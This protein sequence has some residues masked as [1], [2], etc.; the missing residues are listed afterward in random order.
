MTKSSNLSGSTSASLAFSTQISTPSQ[1]RVQCGCISVDTELHTSPTLPSTDTRRHFQQRSTLYLQNVCTSMLAAA[2]GAPPP[3]GGGGGAGGGLGT[4]PLVLAARPRPRR[5]Q[6]PAT[7]DHAAPISPSSFLP[8]LST[9]G[10]LDLNR[11]DGWV[12]DTR[13][14]VNAPIHTVYVNCTNKVK[15]QHNLVKRSLPCIP[16]SSQ[17]QGSKQHT[18]TCST[19]PS[20]AVHPD[21]RRHC[22]R[23]KWFAQ[24]R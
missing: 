15:A 5:A 20:T 2:S 9:A 22:A 23:E 6:Q 1:V 7:C 16:R 10:A 13:T 19:P 4:R 18:S 11:V 17:V 8:G 21:R 24:C 12:E 3:R 14:F